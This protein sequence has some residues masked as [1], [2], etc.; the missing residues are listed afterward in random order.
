MMRV[1]VT[2][3][4]GFIGAHCL[5][6]LLSED[7][8]IHAVNRAG[9]GENT[10]RV[11]WHAGDLRETAQAVALIA[12][13]RPTHLLHCAWVATPRVY[14][15]SPENAD[16]LQSSTALAFAFGAHGGVRFVGI[17]SS[18]EYDPGEL[19][20]VEDETPIRPA[21]IYGKCKAAF[22]LAVQAAAQHHGFSAAWGRVFLPY[23]PGDPAQRLVPAVLASLRAGKPVQTTHG[24]QKR[25]FIYAPDAADLLVRLLL[26]PE[27]GAFNVGTG[28]ATTIRS[29][30]EYLAS[31]CGR[32]E[33][34]QFGA[35][36][37]PAEEPPV[38]VADTTKVHDRLGWSAPTSIYKGL[39]RVL[40]STSPDMAR[41]T[42]Q[43]HDH[44]AS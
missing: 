11:T 10:A 30:V 33:L 17:G 18:A 22:W 2:G 9:Q 39:D 36:Q 19:P 12:K 25:D 4:S 43:G 13:I 44:T 38:L 1:L 24:A 31:R 6:R 21:M 28:H 42:S 20:C 29:V 14:G 32:P 26:S 23:G 37:P 7:C 35:I 16:W 40:N 8:E 27:T 41:Q 3:S 15:H 34:L 5:C